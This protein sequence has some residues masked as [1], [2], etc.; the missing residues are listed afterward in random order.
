MSARI[1]WI[2]TIGWTTALAFA[3]G[4]GGNAQG[5]AERSVLAGVYSKEQAVA[6]KQLYTDT[7]SS[8]H[9]DNLAGDTMSPP[10]VGD[11]FISKWENKPLRALY[12]RIISTMPADAPGT[13]SEKT[14]IDIVAYLLEV[15]G[16]PAGTKPLEKADEMN[17]IMVTR[18]K[19]P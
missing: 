17:T 1:A 18:A 2:G 10:M 8:C 3:F 5:A 14:I 13:L 12:S 7:C 19:Q 6:G 9:L 16:F 4:I 11:D 15:N